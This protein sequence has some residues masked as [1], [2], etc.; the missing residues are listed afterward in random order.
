[1]EG[2]YYIY[3]ARLRRKLWYANI[4]ASLSPGPVE[5]I[6]TAVNQALSILRNG[7]APAEPASLYYEEHSIL[8]ND[9]GIN[10]DGQV[11][12]T[13][14]ITYASI[15]SIGALP[16]YM[17][18]LNQIWY[19]VLIGIYSTLSRI[20]PSDMALVLMFGML[21]ILLVVA[22]VLQRMNKDYSTSGTYECKLHTANETIVAFASVDMEYTKAAVDTVNAVARRQTTPTRT[23]PSASR[24]SRRITS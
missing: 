1:M 19:L 10:V 17:L 4:S 11:Y 15:D 12:P 8:V 23:P 3:V 16:W 20:I 5:Q 6:A 22:R 24:P 14:T 18:V 2:W 21:L 7:A 13:N 9:S